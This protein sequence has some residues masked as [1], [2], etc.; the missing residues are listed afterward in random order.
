MQW[1]E[2]IENNIPYKRE[3]RFSVKY[4][5]RILRNPYLADFILYD[6]IILEVKSVAAIIDNHV[7]QALSYL[8][9]SQQKLGMVINFGEKSLTWKRIVF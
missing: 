6:S 1:I 5:E 2:F 7:Y 9:V 8:S 4:K 3:K